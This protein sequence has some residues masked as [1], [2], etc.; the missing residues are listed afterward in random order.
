M[1]EDYPLQ[2][3]GELPE[4]YYFYNVYS[5]VLEGL[6]ENFGSRE[7][8]GMMGVPKLEEGIG[9]YGTLTFLAVNP[10]S[11][12]LEATLEYISAFAK[13]MLTKQDSFLLEDKSTYTDTPFTKDWYS[14]YANG[15]VYFGVEGDVFLSTFGEYLEDTIDLETA[16]AEMERRRKLY[17]EE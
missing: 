4:F 17:L 13:Y 1:E 12:N 8:V 6:Q 16:I 11:E 2:T 10:Q 14:L 7:D 9:N 15:T 5:R 3:K